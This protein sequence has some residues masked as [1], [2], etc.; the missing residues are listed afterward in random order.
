[1]KAAVIGGGVMGREHLKALVQIPQVDVAAV[2]DPDTAAA[3]RVLGV[4]EIEGAQV[5]DSSDEMLRRVSPDYV[6]VASPVRF[7]AQQTVAAF[8]S[9]AHVMCEKP[10]CMSLEEA[11]AMKQA[12]LTAGRLFTM[13]L[14][15]RQSH[16]NQALQKFAGGGGLGSIYHT[17]VWGGHIMNYPWGRYFHRK[18]HYLGG[19]LA[20]TTV[21]PL[22]VVYWVIGAPEPVAVSG[23]TFCRLTQMPNPPINFEGDLSEVS[24]EDFGH[25]HVRFA[26]GSSMSVEGNWLQHPRSRAHGFEVLGT[27]GV[28]S[29]I[30]PHVQVWDPEAGEVA[31]MELSITEEQDHRTLAEHKNFLAAMD[32]A[33]VS[34]VTLDEAINVQRIIDGIY[35]SAETGREVRL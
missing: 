25:A 4:A 30:E 27:L 7:H 9:G 13:G 31:T 19:V 14:Q 34:L 22:D 15:M 33:A 18:D 29:D 1:M 3:E 28:G 5:F 8:E 21:H 12:A 10:L 11:A 2:V 35:R 24:V 26:D 20:A 23:S 17:R 16:A 32:G 6:V